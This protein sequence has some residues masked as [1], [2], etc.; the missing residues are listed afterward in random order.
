MTSFSDLT[1]HKLFAT[2]A[3]LHRTVYTHAKVK[4]TNANYIFQNSSWSI[5]VRICMRTLHELNLTAFFSQAI[6]LMVVDA[7]VKA[8]DYLDISTSIHDPAEFWKV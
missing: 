6:E 8:N 1:I 3:D 2:R 4:V 7:L 5:N